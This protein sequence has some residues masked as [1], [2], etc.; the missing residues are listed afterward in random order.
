MPAVPGQLADR[1]GGLADK[2]VVSKHRRQLRRELVRGSSL[3]LAATAI[4]S[5]LSLMYTVGVARLLRPDQYG[6]LVGMLSLVGLLAAPA[7]A[8]QLVVARFAAVAAA[9][10]TIGQFRATLAQ[11]LTIMASSA[12]VLMTAGALGAG[13]VARFL[14]LPSAAPVW[15]ALPLLGGGLLLPVLRGSLQ[16]FCRFGTLAALSTVDV[17]CKVVLGLALVAAGFG[18]AGAMAALVVGLSVG[19]LLT[20]LALRAF[21]AIPPEPQRAGTLR[22]MT[23]FS[24]PVLGVSGGLSALSMLDTLLARHYFAPA[25]AGQY[26]A[27]AVAGRSVFWISG[28]VATAGLPLAARGR[29]TLLWPALLLTGAIGL[30]GVVLFHVFSKPIVTILFGAR[31]LAAADLLPDYAWAALLLSLGNIGVNDLL[32]RGHGNAVFPVLAALVTFVGL[33]AIFHSDA[34]QLIYDLAAAGIVFLVALV[35]IVRWAAT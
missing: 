18:S 24:I 23:S 34:L 17:L 19:S 15:W 35:P 29:T 31:F 32:G 13:P 12:A 16:G 33:A 28:A 26:A 8:L 27:I 4:G 7:G 1:L 20:T 3:T 25:E 5:V 14:Q 6:E 9:E 11:L 22:A 10:R 2:T 30:G 21:L